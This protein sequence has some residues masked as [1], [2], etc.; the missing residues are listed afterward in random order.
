[1]SKIR[2]KSTGVRVNRKSTVD[3]YKA[4]IVIGNGTYQAQE[5]KQ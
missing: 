1:M 3:F 5:L 4:I 2:D